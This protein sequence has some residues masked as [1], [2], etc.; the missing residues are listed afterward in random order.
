MVIIQ[1]SSSVRAFCRSAFQEFTPEVIYRRYAAFRSSVRRATRPSGDKSG[2]EDHTSFKIDDWF[3]D[4]LCERTAKAVMR[5]RPDVAI[6]EYVF[7][8]RLFEMLPSTVVKIVDTIDV[9]TNRSARIGGGWFSTDQMN[10][11]TGLNRADRVMAITEE[12]AAWFREICMKPVYCVGHIVP[13]R[14]SARSP[15]DGAFTIGFMAAAYRPNV[16]GLR[17]LTEEVFPEIRRLGIAAH[18]LIVGGVIRERSRGSEDPDLEY[19]RYLDSDEFYSRADVIVN[20]VRMGSGLKIKSIEAIARG[21]ALVST[22]EGV[23]GLRRGDG[24][25]FRVADDPA[26]FGKHLVALA[27][28]QSSR[29][30]LEKNAIIFCEAYNQEMRRELNAIICQ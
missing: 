3:P 20:P 21:K 18:L 26:M 30:T 7:L 6:V 16:D 4:E 29:T 1:K 5:V 9:S 22:S 25:A 10:E 11:A 19:V 28:D 27:L 23:R 12:D 24:F 8:S 15:Q 13:A 17:L 14:P 2:G